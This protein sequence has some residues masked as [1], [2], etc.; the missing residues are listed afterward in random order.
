MEIK[1]YDV[2]DC[3]IPLLNTLMIITTFY[4]AFGLI[5]CSQ[6]N[7]EDF[8]GFKKAIQINAKI[9]LMKGQDDKQ[10]SMNHLNVLL[11]SLYTS[12]PLRNAVFSSE[13]VTLKDEDYHPVTTS[14]SSNP[15][16]LI[17]AK[18]HYDIE[19]RVDVKVTEASIYFNDSYL[20]SSVTSDDPIE[21]YSWLT[22]ELFQNQKYR[23]LLEFGVSTLK[24]SSEMESKV[25]IEDQFNFLSIESQNFKS[26]QNYLTDLFSTKIEEV[27]VTLDGESQ[28]KTLQISKD[29]FNS[30]TI[31]TFLIKRGF[32]DFSVDETI[33][34]KRK[35]YKLNS[36]IILEDDKYSVCLKGVKDSLWY[37]IQDDSFARIDQ[38]SIVINLASKFGYILFYIDMEYES[39]NCSPKPSQELIM[40]SLTKNMI[41]GISKTVLKQSNSPQL[42][43]QSLPIKTKNMPSNELAYSTIKSYTSPLSPSSHLNLHDLSLKK[44]P[45]TFEFANLDKILVRADLSDVKVNLLKTDQTEII[46]KETSKSVQ[47]SDEQKD[48]CD[49]F[50]GDFGLFNE[51]LKGHQDDAELDYFK[52][53]DTHQ[54][55]PSRSMGVWSQHYLKKSSASPPPSSPDE[56]SRDHFA[57]LLEFEKK[58]HK[59]H[60]S[61]AATADNANHHLYERTYTE[62]DGDE[63]ML[64]KAT[65]AKIRKFRSD[66]VKSEDYFDSSLNKQM[67]TRKQ[68]K[69]SPSKIQESRSM[70]SNGLFNR[71]QKEIMPSTAHSEKVTIDYEGDD[72]KQQ[73][74]GDEEHEKEKLKD[75]KKKEKE[76]IKRSNRYDKF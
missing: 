13:A 38:E 68:H 76:T 50:D 72:H 35:E 54:H 64:M 56:S 31:A 48:N 6:I 2:C 67:S 66:V 26:I 33:H 21:F 41:H 1:A 9:P 63:E 59:S 73:E 51:S 17:F 15:L 22:M 46:E 55:K 44:D 24:Q 49:H 32:E 57:D 75:K 10:S 40:N 30:P 3:N 8:H 16:E 37:K 47:D 62:K 58:F 60:I 45:S 52:D 28:A 29:L 69:K 7:N 53:Y 14:T 36:F 19:N 25:L 11:Q 39:F 20:K 12:C 23:K 61:A 18:M 27:F 4:I 70:L 42:K 5:K 71:P 43:Q 74:K 65:L 34:L